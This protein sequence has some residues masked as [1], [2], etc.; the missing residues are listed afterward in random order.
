MGTLPSGAE[1]VFDGMEF[2][3]R[4]L[5]VFQC[6]HIVFDLFHRTCPDQD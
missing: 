2:F 6:F 3:V 1:D 4:K 5:S